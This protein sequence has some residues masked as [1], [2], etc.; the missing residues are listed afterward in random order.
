MLPEF[1]IVDGIVESS[2]GAH[3]KGYR[4]TGNTND[5]DVMLFEEWGDYMLMK[6]VAPM[7]NIRHNRPYKERWNSEA[8]EIYH[9][10]GKLSWNV[11]NIK[12]LIIRGSRNEIKANIIG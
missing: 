12:V 5:T 8:T 2:D 3:R 7:F 4:R 11:E 10:S 6:G 1:R 9:C